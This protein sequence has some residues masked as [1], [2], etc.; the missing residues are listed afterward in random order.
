M[1]EIVKK[2]EEFLNLKLKDKAVNGTFEDFT[3]FI[4]TR[5]ILTTVKNYWEA[6][7]FSSDPGVNTREILSSYVL[8]FFPDI[9]LSSE[10]NPLEEEVHQKAVNLNNALEQISLDI[11]HLEKSATDYKEIFQ[12][13][14]EADQA[15]LLQMMAKSH[16]HIR[17][18]SDSMPDKQNIDKTLNKIENIASSIGGEKAVNHV[19]T[20]SKYGLMNEQIVAEQVLQQMR[21]AFWD[22]FQAELDSD[23]PNFVQY[24]EM[25]GE[26]RSRI[27]QLLPDLQ[28]EETTKLIRKHLHEGEILDKITKGDYGVQEIYNLCIF[29]LERVKELGSASDD[30]D[31][32]KLIDA[33]H[34]QMNSPDR[35]IANIIPVVFR[36]VLER[37]DKILLMKAVVKHTIEEERAKRKGRDNDKEGPSNEP[38]PSNL[39][40]N[41]NN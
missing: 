14:K 38:D 11:N 32:Q 37:L 41:E 12:K 26:I 10:R 33:V 5:R 16:K 2:Q 4:R 18:L 19:K 13:W 22:K 8:G 3:R 34:T 21:N 7:P 20:S 30:A 6:I 28:V 31:V 23:P 25:V 15:D 9:S 24:P 39:I 27:E 1:E 29:S 40:N 36:E 35:N 17:D